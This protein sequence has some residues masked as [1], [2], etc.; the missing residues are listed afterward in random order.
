MHIAVAFGVVILLLILLLLPER[1]GDAHPPRARRWFLPALLALVLLATLRSQAATRLD[2]FTIDEAY[3]IVAG[4]SYVRAG[5]FRLNPEHPPLTKIWVGSALAGESFEMTPFRPLSDKLDERRFVDTV[6]YLDNDPDQVQRRARRVMF[7]LNGILL[8]I[9]GLAARRALGEGIALGAVAFLGIDPTVAAHL[10]VV[11]TDLPIALASATSVLLAA[12][13]FRS[14]RARDLAVVTLALGLPLAVKHSGLV[15]LA[16]VGALG[17]VCALAPAGP[18]RARRL[19]LTVA[20][21]LGAVAVLWGVYDLRFRESPKGLDLFNR[22][23]AEKITDLHT[24]AYREGMDLAVRAHLLPRAYLWGLADILRAGMEGRASGMT[25][26]GRWYPLGV[27]WYFFPGVILVKLPL[28]L[29]LLVLAG[30]ILVARRRDRL[31][32]RF[33]LFAALGLAAVY[34]LLLGSGQAYAGVRHALPVFP[35]LALLAGVAL[36]AAV[37]GGRSIRAVVVAGLLGA[38]VSAL[39][40][41]RPWEYYNELVGGPQ[42]AYLYFADEGIDLGQRTGELVSYYNRELRPRGVVPFLSYP[43]SR[44]QRQRLGIKAVSWL[45]GSPEETPNQVS[46]TVVVSANTLSPAPHFDLTDVRKARPVARFGNLFI[47]QGTFRMPWRRSM[48]FYMQGMKTLYFE[49]APRK[50]EPLFAEAARLYPPH[51]AAAVELGNLRAQRGAR[52]EAIRAFEQARSQATPGDPI[53]E[54]L[55][56]Q[57]RRLRREPPQS[58]PPVRSPWAE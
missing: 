3:H 12:V 5:D 23:L 2:G 15:T 24:P 17:A 38:A 39:P 30:A 6:V 40:V 33:P 42:N 56:E 49:N 31:P 44:E 57:I 13:A 19:V 45:Q 35:A 58:L 26:F 18:G 28:G 34:L 4:A 11:M 22:P 14:W 53:I 25:A 1:V 27:P 10:P 41:L 21:L 50:A 7:T 36:A 8:L 43:L 52:E 46:G 54:R 47:F 51:I 32:D 37:D 55:A 48:A 16:L 9:F 20:V 29:T